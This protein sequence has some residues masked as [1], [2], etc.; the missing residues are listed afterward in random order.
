MLEITFT[1]IGLSSIYN[2]VV[3]NTNNWDFCWQQQQIIMQATPFV[4]GE[5]RQ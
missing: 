1:K 2:R 3:Q 5:T 4:K